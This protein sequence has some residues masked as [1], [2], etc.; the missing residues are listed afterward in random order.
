MDINFKSMVFPTKLMFKQ[1]D[2]AANMTQT[3][4][5]F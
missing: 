2:L 1:R 3:F 5:V 4:T